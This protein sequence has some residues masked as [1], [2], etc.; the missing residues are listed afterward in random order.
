MSAMMTLAPLLTI[1]WAVACPNPDAPPVTI[2]TL[3]AQLDTA[4][5]SLITD[6]DERVRSPT[7]TIRGY[8]TLVV[9]ILA[10]LA[11]RIRLV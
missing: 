10:I 4:C 9:R 1:H 8:L 5:I 2:T 3:F 11:M 7:I 6:R